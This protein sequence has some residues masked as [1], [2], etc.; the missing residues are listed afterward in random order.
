[1]PAVK[2]V[3]VNLHLHALRVPHSHSPGL[4]VQGV[5]R[6]GLTVVLEAH[7]R[8][9]SSGEKVK[10]VVGWLVGPRSGE[11]PVK[12]LTVDVGRR[13]VEGCL[14]GGAQRAE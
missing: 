5:L 2:S 6:R 10:E 8:C 9:R 14:T 13:G 1:M 4:E 3:R 12:C 11:G 7:T